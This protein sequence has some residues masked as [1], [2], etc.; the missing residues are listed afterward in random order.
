VCLMKH[1]AA[2]CI[3]LSFIPLMTYILLMYNV[4]YGNLNILTIICLK[5]F[6]R[7]TKIYTQLR[8]CTPRRCCLS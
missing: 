6:V 8:I 3:I 4:A 7:Y 1:I 5:K 2:N